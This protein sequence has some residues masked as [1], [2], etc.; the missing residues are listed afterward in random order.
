[1]VCF[2]FVVV[3]YL[4]FVV[5]FGM[6]INIVL[7]VF[8]NF[9]VFVLGKN[10]CVQCLVVLLGYSVKKCVYNVYMCFLSL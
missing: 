9:F 1:M 5:I 7:I 8:V 3:D 10:L 6:V 2:G 4:V